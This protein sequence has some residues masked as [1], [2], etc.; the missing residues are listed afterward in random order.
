MSDVEGG[1]KV[2]IEDVRYVKWLEVRRALRAL[3]DRFNVGEV[4]NEYSREIEVKTKVKVGNK[5]EYAIYPAGTE[6]DELM[7][8]YG[9]WLKLTESD[10]V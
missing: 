3:Y 9:E 7:E 6:L 1:C 2:D 10:E 8:V 4:W 5:L